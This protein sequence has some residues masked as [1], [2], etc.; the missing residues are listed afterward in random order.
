MLPVKVCCIQDH[1]ELQLAIRA[2]A[3]AVGFVSKMPSGWGPIPESTIAELAAATPPFV[4]TVLLTSQTDPQGVIEQNRRCRCSV[5][6]LVDAFPIEG[7]ALLRDAFP[8]VR[9]LQAVHVVG[10]EALATAKR[11][12]PHV[13]AVLLDTGSP[14]GETKVLGGTGRTHDWAVSARIVAE[15]DHPVILAGGLKA[16]NVARAVHTVRPWALDLC[17][18]VRTK[19][20]MRLD[21]DLLREFLA[22]TAAAT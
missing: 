8:G 12:A 14:H 2:G 7:Y 5:I 1:E 20:E 6:Q 13:D 19:P 11:I 22:A 4:D 18:G 9:I 3:R 21:P 16:S 15:L 17:T 10:L